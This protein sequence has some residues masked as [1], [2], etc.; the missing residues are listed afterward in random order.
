MPAPPDTDEGRSPEERPAYTVTRAAG[1]LHVS[2]STLRRWASGEGAERA[3]FTPA[4]RSPILLSFSNLVEAFVLASIRRVHGVSMQ[5]VRKALRF[6]AEELGHDRPLL[7]ASFR[8]NGANLFFQ[9]AGRLFDVSAK[10]QTVLR[11]VVD[12]SLTRI[13]WEGDRPAR[14]Y[15]WVRAGSLTRQ[16]KS[17][18]IDPRR[19]SGEPTLLGTDIETRAIAERHRAGVSIVELAR[20]YGVE[21][22]RVED[23][24]RCETRGAA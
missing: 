8:A 18:V 20:E 5:H 24:I 2:A 7:H 10:G 14:L 4:S 1:V 15:P 19:S 3:L 13:D 22:E 16:P 9:H 11:E 6:V 21:L 17:V 23:A 12:E